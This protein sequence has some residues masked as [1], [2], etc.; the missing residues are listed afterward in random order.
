MKRLLAL[1]A[2]LAAS[3]ASA[4]RYD[5]NVTIQNRS[6]W[7]IHEL[8]LSAVDENEWGPDQLG[9]HVIG[10]G[11]DFELTG[12]PCDDYDVRLVDEDD[13]VCIVGSVTLCGDD[14]VWRISNDELL[15]CQMLTDE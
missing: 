15:S 12:I 4:G 6:A 13:D 2:C 5:A 11:E 7:D 8:Y 14:D 3:V 9:R 1:V 10:S